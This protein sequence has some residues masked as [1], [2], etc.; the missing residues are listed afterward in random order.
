MWNRIKKITT[1][2]II[3]ISIVFVFGS[4]FITY[5][6]LKDLLFQNRGTFGD[7]F[8]GLN[9][10]FSG[11]AFAGIIY[12]ILLQREEL[13]L[14]RQ[15]LRYTRTE[16]ERAANAQEKSQL[17]LNNQLQNMELT[18]KLDNLYKY[19]QIEKDDE[20]KNAA[21]KIVQELTG[22]IFQ[23]DEHAELLKPVLIS[24]T[25]ASK[26]KPSKDSPFGYKMAVGPAYHSLILLDVTLDGEV[27]SWI[28][29]PVSQI[30]KT[31]TSSSIIQIEFM[32]HQSEFK[33]Y[34]KFQSPITNRS[35]IHYIRYYVDEHN[36][37]IEYISPDVNE[38]KA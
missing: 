17:A 12:T 22:K 31:L 11:L 2:Q 5:L 15:E 10:L 34:F 35:Y 19:I 23:L 32:S 28:Y 16:L 18:S 25:R 24:R 33:F 1:T 13:K 6:S 14:Q 9:A 38:I 26:W 21:K 36:L 37:V 3:V 30:G 29:N 8:G 20:A 4:W 27:D 7:M